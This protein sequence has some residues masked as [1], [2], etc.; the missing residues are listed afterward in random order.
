M[1]LSCSVLGE[2]YLIKIDSNNKTLSRSFVV[3]TGSIGQPIGVGYTL[4]CI[5]GVL[6]VET[7]SCLV[8]DT[9][10]KVENCPNDY[11]N[12]GDGTC[13]IQESISANAYCPTGTDTGSGC[14][15][16]EYSS[17]DYRCPFAHR[18]IG[19]DCYDFDGS[20]SVELNN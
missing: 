8:T 13:S 18:Q 12:N 4:S 1:L 6:N 20:Y 17:R 5:E 9:V 10:S 16:I 3:G 11:S 15:I 2:S 7:E 14:R 19:Q